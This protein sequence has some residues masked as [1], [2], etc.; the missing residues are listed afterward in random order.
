MQLLPFASPA[1]LHVS[2]PRSDGQQFFQLTGLQG[3]LT[4]YAP[5][6]KYVDFWRPLSPGMV[7]LSLH[8]PDESAAC[9]P[10]APM[11]TRA[12]AAI[13]GAASGVEATV[14]VPAAP[15]GTS[16]GASRMP[17]PRPKQLARIKLKRSGLP[18]SGGGSAQPRAGSDQSA[19]DSDGSGAGI[20]QQQQQQQPMGSGKGKGRMSV[21]LAQRG[22][23]GGSGGTGAGTGSAAAAATAAGNPSVGVGNGVTLAPARSGSGGAERSASLKMLARPPPSKGFPARPGASAGGANLAFGSSAG[24]GGGGGGGGSSGSGLRAPTV[25]PYDPGQPFAHYHQGAARGGP[26]GSKRPRDASTAAAWAYDD[27]GAAARKAS[28]SSRIPPSVFGR[29]AGV[30]SSGEDFQEGEDGDE[31]E[32]DAPG[33]GGSGGGGSGAPRAFGRAAS[34]GHAR[35]GGFGGLTRAGY[36]API[37]EVFMYEGPLPSDLAAAV[38]TAEPAPRALLPGSDH[39]SAAAPVLALPAPS[40]RE[41]R[42]CGGGDGGATA[43]SLGGKPDGP[44][45]GSAHSPG[46]VPLPLLSNGHILVELLVDSGADESTVV[47]GGLSARPGGASCSAAWDGGVGAW[48]SAPALSPTEGCSTLL[49]AQLW[50]AHAASTSPHRP[51]AGRHVRPSN[52]GHQ[53]HHHHLAHQGNGHQ[54]HRHHGHK[55]GHLSTCAGSAFE[56]ASPR[57]D[58][59]GSARAMQVD[60]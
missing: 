54:G 60:A 44:G 40:V 49:H 21:L 13:G 23:S 43:G 17:V 31:W 27:G 59:T 57:A 34:G 32:E 37:V 12:A 5:C 1:V 19:T 38:A 29:A 35:G 11:G 51:R 56:D 50:E 30:S 55:H 14:R 22:K 28:R 45:S 20:V 8:V 2:T 39:G 36:E 18:G 41:E 58:D 9:T 4:A 16:T 46:S 52:G 15:A 10:R 26:H 6:A 47:H 42:S 33:G 48:L 3:A 7:Q 25:R 53:H 24:G